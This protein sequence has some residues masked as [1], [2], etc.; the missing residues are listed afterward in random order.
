MGRQIL[1]VWVCRW[2]FGGTFA[3]AGL[4]GAQ[5]ASP[6]DKPAEVTFNFVVQDEH[7]HPVSDLRPEEVQVFADGKP[8]TVK[9]LRYAGSAGGDEHQEMSLLVDFSS[10]DSVRLANEFA[11]VVMNGEGNKVQVS[12]WAAKQLDLVQPFT[13]DKAAVLEAIASRQQ[14]GPDAVP[15][16]VTK[17]KPPLPLSTAVHDSRQLVQDEDYPPWLATMFALVKQEGSSI[18]R[19]EIVYFAANQPG[20]GVTDEQIQALA[21][22]ACRAGVSIYIVE[23]EL[24]SSKGEA[25]AEVILHGR[26]K[27]GREESDTPREETHKNLLRE[28]AVRTGGIYA[29][30]SRENVHDLMKMAGEDLLNYYEATLSPSVDAPDGH[31]HKIEVKLA[32]A[33]V[34]ARQPSGY[35]SVP[36]VS[37]L[38]V[39]PFEPSLFKVLQSGD[40]RHDFPFNCQIVRFGPQNGKMSATV[41]VEVPLGSMADQSDEALKLS[42]MHFAVMGLIRSADGAVVSKL[43]QDVFYDVPSAQARQARGKVYAF[44]RPAM[45]G[46]GEYRLEVGVMDEN[47]QQIST[48]TQT[49]SIPERNSLFSLGDIVLVKDAETKQEEEENPLRYGAARIIPYASGRIGAAA[50]GMVPVLLT[51]YPVDNG[52]APELELEVFHGQESAG[53]V[54][55]L[56]NVDE[57][58]RYR[59]LVWLPQA[60]L[61]PGHYQLVARAVQGEER[62]EQE[63]EFDL[64]EP[65]AKVENAEADAGP[66][67]SKP[68]FALEEPT[69]VA[70]SKPLEEA[71]L[72]TMLEGARQ[73]ALDYKASLPNFSCVEVTKR[74][75]GQAGSQNWKAI[76][77]VAELL[78]YTSGFEQ[79]ETLEVNGH[80]EQMDRSQLSGL[81]TSGEFGELLDAIYSPEAGAEF[82]SKGRTTFEGIG[83]DVFEYKVLRPRSIYSLSTTWG[84]SRVVTGFRGLVYIDPSSLQTRYVSIQAEE[85]PAE[86][87]YR[88]S[89]VS[90]SYDYVLFDGQKVLLPKTATLNVRVGKRVLLKNEMQF[91]N[92]RR[93]HATSRLIVQ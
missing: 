27:P 81:K 28:L 5:T 54:P 60:T 3:F 79:Y 80:H 59:A 18:G 20:A 24:I 63:T 9:T 82:K 1:A 91:R 52:F 77:T 68:Q 43:S 39:K 25:K 11:S 55:L 37:A 88:E 57:S 31:F 75:K 26:K 21:S 23:N 58:G 8:Q 89:T 83:V 19:K 44:E 73:K 10:S 87:I 65:G 32:R 12:L 46:P 42:R 38:D 78:R 35:F 70:G 86:A 45:L 61:P 2:A 66:E 4:L 48:E 84:H 72:K 14:A 41:V 64:V 33:G 85:I 90:V 49:F 47:G 30:E 7:H 74:F 13:S 16:S 56:M 67:P 76:D 92:Y 71:Q 6:P 62:A 69:L 53:R 40:G 51:L 50:D 93:Y 34:L 17:A 29:M 22:N 36:A 15:S